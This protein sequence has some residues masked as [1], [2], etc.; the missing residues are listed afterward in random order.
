MSFSFTALR[1]GSDGYVAFFTGPNDLAGDNDLFWDRVNNNLILGGGGG[2]LS[3]GSSSPAGLLSIYSPTPQ[4]LAE[5]FTTLRLIA[6]NSGSDALGTIGPLITFNQL[7]SSTPA[8]GHIRTA[9]VCSRKSTATGSNGGGIQFLYQPTTDVPMVAGMIMDHGGSVGIGKAPLRKLDVLGSNS[10]YVAYFFNDGNLAAG[11]GIYIRGGTASEAGTTYYMMC[12]DGDGDSV[13]YIAHVV[14]TFSLTDASDRR[15][16]RDIADTKIQGLNTV[17]KL[18]IREFTKIKSNTFHPAGFI[19]QEL[20][21]VI[22]GTVT[23]DEKGILG[24]AKE[25]LIPYLV[26]SIQELSDKLD[27]RQKII[28]NF[29]SEIETLKNNSGMV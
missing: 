6:T 10:N 11:Y 25:E 12:N 7:W 2:L 5:G 8:T 15:L 13:G 20:K 4:S 29:S 26:K 9:G 1:Q 17:N 23:K 24:I 27:L 22:P 18:R 21:E 19:A 16:K 3:I 14:G 28:D